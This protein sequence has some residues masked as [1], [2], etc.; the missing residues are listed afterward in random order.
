MVKNMHNARKKI[1]RIIFYLT[2]V[3]A[4]AIRTVFVLS[5]FLISYNQGDWV[6]SR[7]ISRFIQKPAIIQAII[8]REVHQHLYRTTM[9]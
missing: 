8:Y 3:N 4:G 2:L 5:N 6:N 7:I 9:L 1:S